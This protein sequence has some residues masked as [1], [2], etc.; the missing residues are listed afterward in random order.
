MRPHLIS[1]PLLLALPLAACGDKTADDTG[2]DDT[3]T[4]DTDTDDTD[5]LDDT[6]D[7][8]A[9]VDADGD[10]FSAEDDCDDG[11]AAVNPGVAEVCNGVDDNCD[12]EVD[13]GVATTSFTDADGDGHGDPETEAAACDVPSGAVEVGDDCDDGDATVFPGADEVCGD[14]VVNDCDGTREAAIAACPIDWPADTTDV[15]LVHLTG[16]A[17]G[18]LAGLAVSSGGDVD[19]DGLADVLVG[20]PHKDVIEYDEGRAYLVLGG[21]SADA[22]LASAAVATVSSTVGGH[23][24]GTSVDIARDIDGDGYDDVVLGAP[25]SYSAADPDRAAVFFGPVSGALDIGA[26]DVA[27]DPAGWGRAGAAVAGLGD[28]DGDGLGDVIV[29]APSFDGETSPGRAYLLLGPGTAAP[30][31]IDARTSGTGSHNGFGAGVDAAGDFDGDGLADIVA[32]APWAGRAGGGAGVAYLIPGDAAFAAGEAEDLALVRMDTPENES[33]FG[34]T[35]AGIGD[36]DGDGKDDVAIGA[37]WEASGGDGYGHGRV[38][39]LL[40]GATG[41]LDTSDADAVV[42]GDISTGQL[43]RSLAPAGDIDGDG[44]DEFLVGAPG[45]EGDE[46]YNNG[47]VYLVLGGTSGAVDVSAVGAHLTGA[48]RAARVGAALAGGTDLDGDG[49]PDAVIGASETDEA[50]SRS[51]GAFL[52]FNEPGW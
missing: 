46:A 52:L 6:G 33:S 41:D 29:G 4:D 1:L 36:L 19:G 43:G 10:G 31:A 22:G 47:E 49:V 17:A 23:A 3:D 30:I 14:G 50:G 45:W 5:V 40:G 7:T 2:A 48:A 39:V 28:I 35:V 13:E 15:A 34:E 51:G 42:T 37:R 32:G 18:D 21:A 11:D 25:G 20:A 44:K 8:H 16:E 12:G 27:V 26:A 9:P 24:V 38:Y